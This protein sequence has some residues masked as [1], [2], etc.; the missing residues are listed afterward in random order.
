MKTKTP[1]KKKMINQYQ[2]EKKRTKDRAIK[3][4]NEHKNQQ[5]S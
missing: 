3:C 5:R 4:R 1:R 2:R